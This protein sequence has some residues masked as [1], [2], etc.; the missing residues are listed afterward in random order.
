MLER[1]PKLHYIGIIQ[2]VN[3]GWMVLR[4]CLLY[5]VSDQDKEDDMCDMFVL[6]CFIK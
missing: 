5:T 4:V 2:E 3:H 6:P 1:Y